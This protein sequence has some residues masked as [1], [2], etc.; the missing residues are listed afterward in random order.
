MAFPLWSSQYRAIE[1]GHAMRTEREIERLSEMLADSITA[2]ATKIGPRHVPL[3]VCA[4][5]TS[6]SQVH[7]GGHGGCWRFSAVPTVPSDVRFQR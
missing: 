7:E 1:R 6:L 4:K 3:A 5:A 2:A